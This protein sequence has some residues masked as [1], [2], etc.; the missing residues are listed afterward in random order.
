MRRL[1]NTLYV[2]IEDA[3]LAKDGEN[4]VVQRGADEIARFPLHTLE[5]II[6][7]SYSGASPALM[8]VCAE[9]GINLCL[10]TQM[11]RF[12]ARVSGKTS[13]NVLLRK[14][15][16]R[17]SD[18]E[19][20]SCRIARNMIIGKVFNCRWSIERT[21][22][23]HSLRVDSERLKSASQRLRRIIDEIRDCEDLARLRGI[24]GEAAAVY[25]GVFDYMVLNN[26]DFFYYR[27]RSKRP[28]LDSLNA[29]LSFTYALLANDCVA[30]LEGAGLD[31]YVGFLH[32]D[33]PGRAS[34][35]LDLMEELR[36]AMADR[37]VLTL[38]NTRVVEP[39]G[40]CTRDDGGVTMTDDCRRKV[41]SAWQEKK[42]EALTHPYLSEKI[43][44][45]SCST[46]SGAP[47]C[48]PSSRRSGGISS[49]PMEVTICS[50]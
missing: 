26:K 29:L 3:Y 33:R 22:R 39:S 23:D 6:S 18:N 12:L 42:K 35:A 36:P 50:Y 1:L 41:L 34:L 46:R 7:F 24:E 15:Q 30:A 38:V 21:S 27:E 14:K 43:H 9:R 25:F 10:M 32:R 20:E 5:N 4:V 17:T 48:A 8:G 28:P 45:G 47:A 11:G 49:I 13:G 40:F 44:W 37:F 19:A 2:T 31:P 16:Y